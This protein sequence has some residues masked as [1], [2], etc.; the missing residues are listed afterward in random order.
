MNIKN[1]IQ[2]NIWGA[3]VLLVLISAL[4]AVIG[5]ILKFAGLVTVGWG[6]VLL[7]VAICFFGFVALLYWALE[8]SGKF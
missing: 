4:W 7:P 1:W 6:W 5:T 2:D 3:S 8:D